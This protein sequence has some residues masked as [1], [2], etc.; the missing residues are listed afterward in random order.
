MAFDLLSF[1][2]GKS[3][4]SGGGGG[5][6]ALG[7]KTIQQ[8]GVYRATSD[9]L[10]GYNTV[11]V[12]VP[13]TYAAAD[14]GKVVSNGALVAQTSRTVTENGTYDTT[15]NDEVVVNVSGGTEEAEW[16]DVC[17]WD[18]DGT[19][20]YSYTANEFANLSALPANPSHT[21]LTAQGWNWTLA[22]AKEFV[23]A[24]GFLDIGQ[25]YVTDDGKTRIQVSL[26]E[27]SSLRIRLIG[28]AAGNLII[29]WGDGSATETNTGTSA[30]TY[31]HSY[32][33]GDFIISITVS[34]GTLTLNGLGGAGMS[35]FREINIGAN[36]KLNPGCF[37]KPMYLS[38]VSIPLDCDVSAFGG[39]QIGIK[40]LILPSNAFTTDHA[41]SNTLTEI[42]CFAKQ[43]R[44]YGTFGQFAQ[45]W[46]LRRLSASIGRSGT[47][48]Q[49]QALTEGLSLERFLITDGVTGFGNLN[50][51][52]NLYSLKKITIP[53]SITTIPAGSFSNVYSL[54]E[55]H[56]L[57]TTPPTLGDTNVW[58]NRPSE[59]RIY[60]PYSEDHSILAAY[61]AAT[62]WSTFASYMQ[63][64]PQ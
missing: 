19:C 61:Q 32:T 64:E 54:K 12:E 60:V 57:A 7:P 46:A 47:N 58:S 33:S 3:T 43:T 49:A 24:N 36:V 34:N 8:N 45:N 63:E 42:I 40:C 2:I 10:D 53:A 39:S 44:I 35:A 20:L 26:R 1:L 9:N 6:A 4:G 11:T 22:D 27:T 30:T 28:S 59:F 52:Q 21:G 41:Y 51:T 48:W 50:S 29:D 55:V 5:S 18:Y 17:F 38:R 15:L 31:E 37:S 14:N 56:M 25:L 62:N 16:N 13:N 23:S